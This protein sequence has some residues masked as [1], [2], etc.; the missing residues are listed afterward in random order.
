MDMVGASF[1]DLIAEL[2]LG[3]AS[4]VRQRHE[5]PIDAPVEQAA[6]N[7]SVR[8]SALL[9]PSRQEIPSPGAG[10]ITIY[11]TRNCC[12]AMPTVIAGYRNR[13]AE[14]FAYGR[15]VTEFSG[16]ARQAEMYLY[17]LE[18]ATINDPWPIWFGWPEAIAGS[19]GRGNRRYY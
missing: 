10:R 7:F 9:Q 14:R 15:N 2:I 6:D 11:V 16:S 13:A 1:G 3:G 12:Y 8:I 18:T 5:A 4:V 17:V 19:S